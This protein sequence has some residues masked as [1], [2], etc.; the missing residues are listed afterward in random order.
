[1]KIASQRQYK[2]AFMSEK[3]GVGKTTILI[4]ILKALN[5]DR[6]SIVVNTHKKNN[7]VVKAINH[8]E[9]SVDVINYDAFHVSDLLNTGLLKHRYI[10]I[11]F[12][13]EY[14]SDDTLQNIFTA[15]DYIVIPAVPDLL[16]VDDLYAVC[17]R[18][19]LLGSKSTVVF[20]SINH[21]T[22]E[23]KIG[24]EIYNKIIKIDNIH[25]VSEFIENVKNIS[26]VGKTLLNNHNNNSII[27][28][29]LHNLII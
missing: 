10:L 27:R 22:K 2:I 28:N 25:V 8:A 17:S 12:K 7:G 11:D 18:L 5:K 3:G 23:D 1:M 24:E 9:L 4:S 21:V 20:N 15:V 13:S 6:H 16:G 19:S 14:L 26:K 29:I